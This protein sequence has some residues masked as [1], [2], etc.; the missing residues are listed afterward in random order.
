MVNE[1]AKIR[2][3]A[4]SRERIGVIEVMGNACGDLAL[5]AGVAGEAEYI[6]VPEVEFDV[7]RSATAW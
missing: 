7:M 6:I 2:D 3:D 4:V 5:A 1:I